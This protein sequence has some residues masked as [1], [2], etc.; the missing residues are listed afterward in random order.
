M[1]MLGGVI[2]EVFGE[3]FLWPKMLAHRI[4]F[5]VAVEGVFPPIKH[6]REMIQEVT[7]LCFV[8]N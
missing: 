7:S 5:R 3:K 8:Y 4:M 1:Y 6:L 2:T